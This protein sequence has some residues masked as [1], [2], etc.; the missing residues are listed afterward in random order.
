M[1]CG[2]RC[3]QK[4]VI[5]QPAKSR[6]K[7]SVFYFPF[8]LLNFFSWLFSELFFLF[9]RSNFPSYHLIV[10]SFP[11]SIMFFIQLVD[12]NFVIFLLFFL[13]LIPFFCVQSGL[14]VRIKFKFSIS[15]IYNETLVFLYFNRSGIGTAKSS[16][17]LK[18]LEHLIIL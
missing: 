1:N 8:H 15:P 18:I 6:R 4:L 16:A 13:V 7:N 11:C 12:W 2:W 17:V 10:F 5:N 14:N 3:Q 9:R